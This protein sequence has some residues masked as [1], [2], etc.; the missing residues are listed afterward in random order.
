MGI[1]KVGFTELTQA[2]GWGGGDSQSSHKVGVRI[3]VVHTR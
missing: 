2:E 3:H 1:Y